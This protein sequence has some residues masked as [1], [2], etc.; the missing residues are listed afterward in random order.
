LLKILQNQFYLLVQIKV[1]AKG[2]RSK[3]M[4]TINIVGTLAE[5]GITNQSL[6]IGPEAGEIFRVNRLIIFIR[7]T[8]PLMEDKYGM[9]ITLANGIKIVVIQ[10]RPLGELEIIR[11]ITN[12][13]PIFTNADWRALCHDQIVGNFTGTTGKTASYRYDFTKDGEAL[14][15]EGDNFQ[16]LVVI[17]DDDFSAL[18]EHSFRVGLVEI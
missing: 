8:G 10:K 15:L 17:L 9:N 3:Y 14:T 6:I 5:L 11:D 16:A 2:F 13:R 7:T 1:M 18:E 4:D 12:G